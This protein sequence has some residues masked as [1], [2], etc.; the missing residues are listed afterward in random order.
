MKLAIVRQ[1]GFLCLFYSKNSSLQS[2]SSAETQKIPFSHFLYKQSVELKSF[3]WFKGYLMGLVLHPKGFQLSYLSCTIA[4]I[5]LSEYDS[6]HHSFPWTNRKLMMFRNTRRSLKCVWTHIS[7][8]NEVIIILTTV[9]QAKRDLNDPENA[10]IGA[11]AGKSIIVQMFSLHL[12]M[13]ALID[14]LELF[15]NLN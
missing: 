15:F 3:M 9:S 1:S 12:Y 14:S 13:W 7:R 4:G 11:F 5:L 6:L 2:P 10:I 8:H